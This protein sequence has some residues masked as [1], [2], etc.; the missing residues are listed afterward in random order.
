M[1]TLLSLFILLGTIFLLI[2]LI[3][4]F[5]KLSW[6]IKIGIILVLIG[7]SHFFIDFI[8]GLIQGIVR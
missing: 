6:L 2:G 7:E 4:Y 5:H 8:L 3:K 1:D